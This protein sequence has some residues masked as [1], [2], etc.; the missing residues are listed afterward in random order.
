M[1]KLSDYE[2]NDKWNLIKLLLTVRLVKWSGEIFDL[3]VYWRVVKHAAEEIVAT[4][5]NWVVERIKKWIKQIKQQ[6]ECRKL[7]IRQ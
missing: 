3:I 2:Q 1:R 6:C 5:Q 4:V 7:K